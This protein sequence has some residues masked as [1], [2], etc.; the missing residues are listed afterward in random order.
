MLNGTRVSWSTVEGLIRLLK[1][2]EELHLSLNEYKTVELDHTQDENKNFSLK[3][4]HFTGNPVEDWCEIAKLGHLFPSLESL[5]LAECPIRSLSTDV[6]E[7]PS[8]CNNLSTNNK[9][10]QNNQC[11]ENMNNLPTA[12]DNHSEN[13]ISYPSDNH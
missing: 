12:K 3:K 7:K 6:E 10:Q 11:E 4:L 13:R 5:V 2:L 1:N 8:N 9:Q